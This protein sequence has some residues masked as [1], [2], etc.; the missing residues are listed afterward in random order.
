MGF[1]E[2]MGP[3]PSKDHSLDRIDNDGNYEPGNCRW[4]TRKE[5]MN[6]RRVSRRVTYKG[7][8]KTVAEWAVTLGVGWHVVANRLNRGWTIERALETPLQRPEA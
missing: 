8:V 5:Q 1:I 6:N 4:A 3:R 2:D 7:Q